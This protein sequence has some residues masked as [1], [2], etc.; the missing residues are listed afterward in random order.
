MYQTTKPK[1]HL[2]EL[3]GYENGT[4]IISKDRTFNDVEELIS[5]LAEYQRPVLNWDGNPIPGEYKN[6]FMESQALTGIMRY[7]MFENPTEI[8]VKLNDEWKLDKY[9]FWLDYPG[10]PNFDVRTLKD[11]VQKQ[12]YENGKKKIKYMTRLERKQDWLKRMREI[13]G[14]ACHHHTP[15]RCDA[16]YIHRARAAYGMLAEP[17]YKRFVKAK[18][19]VFKSIWVDED[20]SLKHNGTGW[21]ES[22]KCKHQWEA[23]CNREYKTLNHGD[24]AMFS[25][26]TPPPNKIQRTQEEMDEELEILRKE[27]ISKKKTRK[28]RNK[29]MA[30]DR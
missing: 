15:G 16:S 20:F 28:H 8:C 13:Q 18:D 6:V 30:K 5:F 14:G 11:A 7:S 24:I 26:S 2:S 23:K 1:I 29:G 21:K 3:S 19:K 10:Q 17:E 22:T 12:H 25:G 4:Y 27:L 9:L